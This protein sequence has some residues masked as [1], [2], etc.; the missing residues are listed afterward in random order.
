MTLMSKPRM[1]TTRFSMRCS[2]I[3][4][5]TSLM[6]SMRVNASTKMLKQTANRNT[7]L[8]MAPITS[9]RLQP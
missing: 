6:S 7:L 5:F 3:P 4:S 9:K 1:D 8:I 2:V